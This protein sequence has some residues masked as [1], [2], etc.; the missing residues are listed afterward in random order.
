MTR[1]NQFLIEG[2]DRLGK[3]TLLQGIQHRLG[4]HRVMHYTK[5]V[6]PDDYP[7][8]TPPQLALK[9]YQESV[10]RVMFKILSGS[11]SD[12]IIHNRAHLGE[13][14][15][16]PIYR[17]YAGEYVFDLEREFNAHQFSHARLILLVEDF[18]VSKHF[19]DDG[20]SL[21]GSERRQEEQGLFLRAFA[22]SIFPD[23]RIVCVTDQE[24]GGFRS[25]DS[26][27]NEVLS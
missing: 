1:L 6:L 10:F 4:D 18:A 7:K 26:I 12:K 8:T 2:L 9:Q 25:R 27:L 24:T 3:D 22:A 16:A 14:V 15:Y 20:K 5:P 17:K 23:K 13:C 11:R 21:G 19:V